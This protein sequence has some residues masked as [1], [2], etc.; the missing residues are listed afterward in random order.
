MR[1]PSCCTSLLC[2][3]L[4]FLALPYL[5]GSSTVPGATVVARA[6]TTSRAGACCGRLNVDAGRGG[7]K[8]DAVLVVLS[9]EENTFPLGPLFSVAFAVKRGE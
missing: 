4:S 8:E 6:R 5:E 7:I 9:G 1:P 2:R 3:P